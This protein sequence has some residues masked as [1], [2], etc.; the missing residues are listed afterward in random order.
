M[1]FSIEV[2]PKNVSLDTLR[3]RMKEN[4]KFFLKV[5]FAHVFTYTLCGILFMNLFSYWGWIHEQN[6]W[7]DA[8]SITVQLAP[9]F[10]I[11][12]GILY[13]IVLFLIKDAIVYSKY[14]VI[15]LFVIM[16]ILGILNTP[17]TSPGSIEGYIYIIDNEPINIKIG[18]MLEI[19]TQNL[20]FCI[21][22]CTKWKKQKSEFSENRHFGTKITI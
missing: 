13:C 20:L 12:R 18:G 8:G 22:V 2:I 19:L 6:N 11:I 4:I 3:N 14:G 17:G 10:Q 21:I 16:I 1:E 7:R 15:K 9:V 5:I